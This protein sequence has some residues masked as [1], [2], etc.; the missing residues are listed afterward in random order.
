MVSQENTQIAKASLRKKN[1][2]GDSTI[3]EFE[4]HYKSVV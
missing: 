1:K 4:I 2:A 3:P